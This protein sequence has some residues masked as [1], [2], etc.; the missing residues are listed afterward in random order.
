[1]LVRSNCSGN[2]NSSNRRCFVLFFFLL[3]SVTLKAQ[4]VYK[5]PSGTKY[6]LASC[7]TVKNVSEV[8]TKSKAIELGLQPCKICKPQ[9]FYA[10][11]VTPLINKAQ[12]K[13]ETVQCKGITKSGSRCRH[14]TRIANG[15]CFQHNPEK[16]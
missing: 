1:L 2:H 14:K 8:I 10:L 16:D 5:T 12:G 15:Y 6:H 11:G 9:N 3:I 13:D 7:H 4:Q